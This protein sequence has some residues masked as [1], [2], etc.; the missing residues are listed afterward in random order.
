MICTI[1]LQIGHTAQ[2][3][4]ARS[5]NLGARSPNRGAGSEM[6]LNLS[7]GTKALH[8]GVDTV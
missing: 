2:G 1:F 3:A 6:Q 5:Y 7:P 8:Y 4:G